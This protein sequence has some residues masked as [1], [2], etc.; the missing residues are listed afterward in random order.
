MIAQTHAPGPLIRGAMARGFLLLPPGRSV[1]SMPVW[2]VGALFPPAAVP[3]ALCRKWCAA[4]RTWT[5]LLI[6]VL[7][8]SAN[9][10][11]HDVSS[12]LVEHDIGK[13]RPM[14]LS[15]LRLDFPLR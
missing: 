11:L 1:G 15:E 7:V 3:Y 12:V 4:T 9:D 2:P 5:T 10:P 14:Q 13:A 8:L 6:A